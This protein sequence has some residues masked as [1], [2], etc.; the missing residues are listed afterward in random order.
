MG[1]FNSNL[2]DIFSTFWVEVFLGVGDACLKVLI[3]G[4]LITGKALIQG[5]TAY[6]LS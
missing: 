1:V 3:D 6:I 2:K 5:N 4:V